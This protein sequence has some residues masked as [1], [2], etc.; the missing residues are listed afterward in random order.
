MKLYAFV[1]ILSFFILW[2]LITLGGFKSYFKTN[3]SLF[4]GVALG[5]V[6]A[7]FVSSIFGAKLNDLILSSNQ[8]LFENPIAEFFALVLIMDLW[9]YAWHRMNHRFPFLWRFHRIHHLDESL[10]AVSAFR[11]HFGEVA[12][13]YLL[14]F[15][16]FI[17]LPVR[18]ENYL[19]F[20]LCYGFFNIFAH[21]RI[22]LNHKW[23]SILEKLFVTPKFHRLHHHPS[24]EIHDSNYGTIFSFWDRIFKTRTK[25]EEKDN[26]KFGIENNAPENTAKLLLSPFQ[27]MD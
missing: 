11:F 27:S 9:T 20:E 6:N 15:G 12:L 25:I 19:V 14:R 17:L 13:S 16:I 8:Y 24:R 10:N 4:A 21:S 5:A 23:E 22:Q 2:E 1:I 3:T 26:F 7:V 18:I